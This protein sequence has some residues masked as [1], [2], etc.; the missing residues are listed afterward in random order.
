MGVTQGKQDGEKLRR[1]DSK[2]R[3]GESG[4]KKN[5]PVEVL[6]GTKPPARA[7]VTS[8]L[9]GQQGF[10]EGVVDVWEKVRDQL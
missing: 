6:G 8:P 3:Q 10:V 4:M 5:K 9:V 1:K 2:D 7:A